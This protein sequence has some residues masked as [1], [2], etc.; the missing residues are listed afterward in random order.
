MLLILM[1]YFKC[2]VFLHLDYPLFFSGCRFQV[3]VGQRRAA[4]GGFA[5]KV[6]LYWFCVCFLALYDVFKI[7]K[8]VTNLK[9]F[10]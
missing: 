5:A 4:N 1:E 8:N 9:E 6:F 10:Q 3:P 2:F 7:K